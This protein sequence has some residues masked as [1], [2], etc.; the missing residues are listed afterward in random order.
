MSVRL[1][2]KSPWLFV[3]GLPGIFGLPMTESN[4]DEPDKLATH[5]EDPMRGKRLGQVRDDNAL[6]LKLV[7]C[8][9][10]FVTME[11]VEEITEVVTPV[12][13]LVSRGYWLGKYEVSQAEWKQVMATEPWKDKECTKEGDDFP[14][15]WV[16]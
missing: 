7:W 5:A 12:K 11:Q 9:P 14:A 6:K 16:S 3:C 1:I 13:V 2:V 10:G 8:P 4:A 15:T